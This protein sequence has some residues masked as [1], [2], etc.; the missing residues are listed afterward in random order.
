MKRIPFPQPF[1]KA[2]VLVLCLCLLTPAG[3]AADKNGTPTSA[4]A[5]PAVE[6]EQAAASDRPVSNSA[7]ELS[8]EEAAELS[9]RAEEP[10]PDVAGGALSNLHLTYIV[11]ALA[12]AVIVLIAK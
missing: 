12:A 4:T 11:I 9:A 10:G 1:A 2:M 5:A 7:R 6:G 3:I 8:Q